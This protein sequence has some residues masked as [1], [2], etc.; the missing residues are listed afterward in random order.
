[1]P[2][3]ALGVR[4]GI[5]Q[6]STCY[7][8]RWRQ[9]QH[10]QEPARSNLLGDPCS[11]WL[12]MWNEAEGWDFCR[13]GSGEGTQH[14]SWPWTGQQRSTSSSQ[15]Q[16]RSD[17]VKLSNKIRTEEG[18]PLQSAGHNPI[19]TWFV[20]QSC[21]SRYLCHTHILNLCWVGGG[22]D[23]GKGDRYLQGGCVDAAHDEHF[24]YAVLLHSLIA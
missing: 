11:A 13:Q 23:D 16:A 17:A 15:P 3:L 14:G 18:E 10:S 8:E 12:Q 9:R 20:T 24:T 1:M 21:L 22:V 6:R 19:L 2:H 7:V 5:W 4:P